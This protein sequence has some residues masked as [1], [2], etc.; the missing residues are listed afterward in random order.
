LIANYLAIFLFGGFDKKIA[1]VRSFTW[2]PHTYRFFQDVIPGEDDGPVAALPVHHHAVDVRQLCRVEARRP[3]FALLQ[4]QQTQAVLQV[5]GPQ[6]GRPE[7]VQ[8][9]GGPQGLGDATTKQ[10][11]LLRTFGLGQLGLLVFPLELKGEGV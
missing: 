7:A 8:R 9:L 11:L 6:L 5:G 4:H 3:K 1:P 10:P 2:F